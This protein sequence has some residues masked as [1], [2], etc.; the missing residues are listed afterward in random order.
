MLVSVKD[1]LAMVKAGATLE[2]RQA[3]MD[4]QERDLELRNEN[5]ALREEVA[6]LKARLELRKNV[7][8]DDGC[9][10][11]QE[12]GKRDGVAPPCRVLEHERKRRRD[13]EQ[14]VLDRQPAEDDPVRPDRQ[15]AEQHEED[16]EA[17]ARIEEQA[18]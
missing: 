4:M 15:H 6:A 1:M 16:E 3:L 9:Y 5:L 17:D 7:V 18:F 14:Q 13:H 10:W 11:K 8:Y 2:L 12:G